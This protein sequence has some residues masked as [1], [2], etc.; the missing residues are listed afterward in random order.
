[1]SFDTTG[2]APDEFVIG[3]AIG[4]VYNV[5]KRLKVG[6]FSQNV[7]WDDT[8]ATQLQPIIAYQLGDGW[9]LSAGDAQFTYDGEAKRWTNIPIGFQLGKVTKFGQLPVRLAVKPQ[10]NRKDD[11][12]LN[13]WSV[14]F[15][16]TALFPISSRYRPAPAGPLSRRILHRGPC[17]ATHCI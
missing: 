8:A 14:T 7:F 17:R 10:Y 12:G 11:R 5:S 1:M 15:T 9:S 6:L 3:A 2:D 16:F 4:G 13:E